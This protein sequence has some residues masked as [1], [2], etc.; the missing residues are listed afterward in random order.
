M[1]RALLLALAM[2]VGLSVLP[3]AATVA[4]EKEKDEDVLPSHAKNRAAV[5]EKL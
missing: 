3:G 2:L 1:R 5:V 4:A